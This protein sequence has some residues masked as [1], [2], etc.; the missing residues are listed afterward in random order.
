MEIIFHWRG[1][2]NKHIYAYYLICNIVISYV[3]GTKAWL[4]RWR[5]KMG[6][7][8]SYSVAK[9]GFTDEGHLSRDPN[10]VRNE[11]IWIFRRTFQVGGTGST[12]P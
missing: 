5:E 2:D 12:D 6:Q 4:R 1:T 3:M 11:T 10:K 9:E 8:N 7:Y